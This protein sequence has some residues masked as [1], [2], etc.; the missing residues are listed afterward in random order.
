MRDALRWLDRLEEPLSVEV[1][2]TGDAD[3]VGYARDGD[4]AV[5][6]LIRV[7]GGRVVGRE[8]RFLEGVEEEAGQRR[9]ERVPGALLR[10][11]RGP[12]PPAGR[13]VPAG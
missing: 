9:P 3:V 10:A 7:R 1:M 11:R 2:G 4:D 12:G 5:G 13:P 8:H 6:V